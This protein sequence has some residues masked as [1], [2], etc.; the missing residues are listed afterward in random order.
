[1]RPEEKIV[2]VIKDK[3]PTYQQEVQICNQRRVDFADCRIKH[4]IK[5]IIECK[6]TDFFSGIGQLLFYEIGLGREVKK[7]LAISYTIFDY[8]DSDA[9][10]GLLSNLMEISEKYKIDI[11]FVAENR[12]TMHIKTL[13]TK[14]ILKLEKETSNCTKRLI[15]ELREKQKCPII[16]SR[17]REKP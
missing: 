12:N 8:G 2:K 1:M 16:L 13:F 9:V 14:I 10:Y 3:F 4:E 15:K 17:L 7:T 11:L 5:H 6:D